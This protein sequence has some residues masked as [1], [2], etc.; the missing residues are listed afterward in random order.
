MD[1][2][3]QRIMAVHLP[4]IEAFGRYPDSWLG[5][6]T[7]AAHGGSRLPLLPSGPDGVHASPLRGTQSSTLLT[8]GQAPLA[9]NLGKEFDP[10]LAG[11]GYRAPL[12]PRL[13]RPKF[14]R[15]GWDSNPRDDSSPTRSPG[16]LLKPDSDT[17][18]RFLLLYCTATLDGRIMAERV[19]FEPTVP[20]RELGISSAAPSAR[21]DHLSAFSRH[22]NLATGEASTIIAF[23]LL[24][25]QSAGDERMSAEVRAIHQPK[26]RRPLQRGG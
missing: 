4:S 2:D 11:C 13:A 1:P 26:R 17:S 18:P 9:L 16:V 10:A 15:R 24:V 21:L 8:R 19:G 5:L 6:G 22:P 20:L 25:I 12:P 3:S 23:V 14:L 7:P